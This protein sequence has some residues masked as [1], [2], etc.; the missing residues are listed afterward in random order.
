MPALFAN[1]KFGECRRSTTYSVT[2]CFP[3]KKKTIRQRTLIYATKL[4]KLLAVQATEVVNSRLI[5]ECFNTY[6]LWD[7]YHN[8]YLSID[9]PEKKK[10]R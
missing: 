1:E 3:M 9:R 5:R 2:N 7:H 10:K 8:P 6:S 4:I